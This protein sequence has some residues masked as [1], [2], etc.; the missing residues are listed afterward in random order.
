MNQN[1]GI[2]RRNQNICEQ[3]ADYFLFFSIQNEALIAQAQLS[4]FESSSKS[5]DIS[6][7]VNLF[8]DVKK[9]FS[10]KR[11]EIEWL[12]NVNENFFNDF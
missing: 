7:P 5:L 2:F 4:M 3:G 1:N 9:L 11:C 10:Q 6:P 8:S 12:T